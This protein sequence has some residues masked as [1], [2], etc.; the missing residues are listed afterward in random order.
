[1]V[2]KGTEPHTAP[3]APRSD[4]SSASVADLVKDLADPNLVVRLNA[5]NELAA[6][7]GDEVTKAVQEE[8]D[9]TS[10]PWAK[11]H[12]LWVLHR[13]GSL[14]E[15]S[16]KACAHD[17]AAQVRVHAMRVLGERPAMAEPQ[18]L[19]VVSGLKDTDPF[20]RRAAAEAMGLHPAAV[21]V[22]PL[23]DLRH[24]VPAD[25]SH[26]LHMVRMALRNQLR[27]GSAWSHLPAD[28]NVRD[29]KAIA[30][31]APGV[32]SAEAAA[33]L[34]AH[35][36]KVKEDDG[37]LVRYVHH[38]ARHGAGDVPERLL[39]FARGD[40]PGKLGHQAALLRAIVQGTQERGSKLSEA[41][42]KWAAGVTGKLV[43]SSQPGEAQTGFELAGILKLPALR[44]TIVAAAG[45]HKVGQDRRVAAINALVAIDA[46]GTVGL[47]GPILADAT[48]DVA[49]REQAAATLGRINLPNSQDELVKSL[50]TAPGRLQVAIAVN[51]AGGGPLA[52]AKLLD[53]VT[54]GKASARLLQERGVEV[55]LATSGVSRLEERV[56]ELTAGLPPTDQKLQELF[57]RR[58]AGLTAAHTD[59][60]QGA[61]V[62]VKSCG[63]CHQLRG[64]GAKVGPQLDGV[65][66]R[67]ADRLL[68]DI[69]DPNRNVDLQFRATTLALNNGQVVTGLVLREEGQIVVIADAEGKELRIP[70]DTIEERKVTPLSPMPANLA[71]Q[72]SEPDFYNLI[73]YLL[74][75]QPPRTE[76]S[77]P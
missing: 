70:K 16:L 60:E 37:T 71:D 1:V 49:M 23:L 42:Q 2:Y 64:Q 43:A 6:R 25:D 51:L 35:L 38:V 10:S 44:P 24:A 46:P 22:R 57:N 9:L 65:G 30:D 62:F 66:L 8:L 4:W 26:L 54:A 63:T 76:S 15:R 3:K 36:R 31:V 11:V 73:A 77:R 7:Q 74:T 56:K 55:R 19:L 17:S 72:I 50:P 40:Q 69:L 47:L 59:T 53:A 13:R 5:T 61:K 39:E 67:G 27:D 21:N 14:E 20:V 48:E 58:R 12:A 41:A 75:Q 32:P 45:D 68:E 52:A 33:F 28:L 18:R 29:A 34:L